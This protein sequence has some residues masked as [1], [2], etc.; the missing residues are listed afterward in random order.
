M[1]KKLLFEL[2][3]LATARAHTSLSAKEV[4]ESTTITGDLNQP[5]ENTD[6]NCFATSSVPIDTTENQS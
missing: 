2:S 3:L 1:V 6:S 4:W 5:V